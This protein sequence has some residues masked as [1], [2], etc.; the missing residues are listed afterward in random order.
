MQTISHKEREE[1]QSQFDMYVAQDQLTYKYFKEI[2]K[3]EQYSGN[4]IAQNAAIFISCIDDET[5]VER[6]ASTYRKPL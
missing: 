4:F 3:N 2:Y 1:L 5:Q 6:L